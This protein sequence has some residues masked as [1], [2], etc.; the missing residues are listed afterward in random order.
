[1]YLGNVRGSKFSQHHKQLDVKSREFWN[2]NLNELGLYDLRAILDYI[3]HNKE[4]NSE[5]FYIGH[6]QGCSNLLILLSQIPEY[7]KMIKE[8]HLLTPAILLK[9]S[10]SSLL[11]LCA[12][13]V[14]IFNVRIIFT[15]LSIFFC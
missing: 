5:L 7:N 11:T 15:S 10:K 3:S 14:N 2:F 12:E 8:A 1:M 9:N 6:S 4:N 13:H